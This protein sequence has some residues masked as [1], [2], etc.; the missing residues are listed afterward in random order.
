MTIIQTISLLIVITRII[1]GLQDTTILNIVPRNK[2]K[3]GC[4]LFAGARLSY[5]MTADNCIHSFVE[6]LVS[7]SS[8]LDRLLALPLS[9]SLSLFA[10]SFKLTE[11]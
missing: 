9:L 3:R 7:R 4:F 8:L 5:T 11:L 6:R 2:T 1:I 10:C